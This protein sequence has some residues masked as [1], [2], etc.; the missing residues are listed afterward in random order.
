MSTIE[1]RGHVTA[2]AD[3]VWNL[4]GDFAG[5][6][7]WNPFVAAAHIDGDGTGMTRVIEASSGTRIIERLVQRDADARRIRYAVEVAPG[8]VS[9]ADIRLIDD[10]D[11]GT[12]IVWLSERDAEPTQNQQR[13]I[14]ETLV[15]RIE[16]LGHALAAEVT[17]R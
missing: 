15:S 13:T 14:S 2:S 10:G 1:V 4:I 3:A 8:A 12:D 7:R 16:A 5:V 11:G 6:A 17:V 9:F